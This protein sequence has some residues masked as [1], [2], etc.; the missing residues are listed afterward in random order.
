[1]NVHFPGYGTAEAFWAIV[2]LMLVVVGGL[3]GFF[4]YKRWL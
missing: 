4:K 3:V 2:G 1:M